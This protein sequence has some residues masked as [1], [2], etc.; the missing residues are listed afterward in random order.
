MP[1]HTHL[2]WRAV[3]AIALM[4]SFYGLALTVAG[5]LLVIPFLLWS[6]AKS[7]LLKV[8]LFCLIG[9]F[10]ILKAILPRPDHFEPPGP[11]LTLEKQPALFAEIRDLARRTGQDPPA[12]VYL[13]PDVNA[14]VG[15][16]GGF[17]GLGS[18]RVMG[19]GLPLLQTLTLPELRGVLA[20]E[21]GHFHGGDVAIGPWIY[22]T[23][24]ALVRTVTELASHS[25]ALSQVF[26]WYGNL[27]FRITHAVSRHQELLADRLAADIVGKDAFASG[28]RGTNSAGLAFVPYWQ[29]T[30]AP[31]LSAG[32][33]PP[34][35]AG[36]DAFLSAPSV[37]GQ[38]AQA[39]KHQALHEK[40]NPYDTH[41]PL[42][43]RLAALGASRSNT[44][45]VEGPPALT[46]LRDVP[47]LEA[48]LV[49]VLAKGKAPG[50][51]GWEE[52]GD[53]VW[54]PMW[55]GYATKL[56]SVLTGVTP[57][58]LPTTAWERIGR[59]FLGRG[60]G[61]ANEAADFV[62]GVALALVLSRAGF[63][64]ESY[65]GTPHT[66]VGLGER[67]EVF[68]VRER[69]TQGAEAADSWRD[70]CS[71]AGIADVDL[72]TACAQSRKPRPKA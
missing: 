38:L 34:L 36:F 50:R 54:L 16:R 59:R 48:A 3:L 62:V 46:L 31:V 21:F 35:A 25:K 7:L 56:E 52:V 14:W 43:E 32:F 47:A 17:M 57:A 49:K 41:P 18:R 29:G 5:A 69:L 30:V 60:T 45:R 39:L 66:L 11:Q 61:D 20:H 27:F 67:I 44:P 33:A 1:G 13:I 37:A 53:K 58:S 9:A 65:P 15:Q 4:L 71:R 26:L 55:H 6:V 8:G 70:F 63:I 51:L 28:L 64:L 10:A 68:S 72:G 42:A 19:I 12:E 23:R 2:A 40:S 24:A 22:K